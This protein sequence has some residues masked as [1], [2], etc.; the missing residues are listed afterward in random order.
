MVLD[1]L[2]KYPKE[3]WALAKVKT[4]SLQNEPFIHIDSD[5][6]IWSEF[7]ERFQQSDLVAQ[8]FEKGTDYYNNKFS[9]V[10]KYLKYIPDH[11]D[12]DINDKA[13]CSCN[14]GV[15]GGT[16]FNFF[17]KYAAYIFDFADGNDL[18]GIPAHV[19][20]NFNILFEQVFF[21]ELSQKEGKQI[22]CLFDKTIDD[23]GYKYDE[24]ADF[25]TVPYVNTYL[26]LIGPNKRNERACD[27]MSRLLLK[28]HPECFFKIISLFQE[29][30][31]HFNFN[32]S[33]AEEIEKEKI[34]S[35]KLN[36]SVIF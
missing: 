30:H 19:L 29:S 31:R 25:T 20:T 21:Y 13:V 11:F 2:Q 18:N 26:H 17:K 34:K 24:I 3:L 32:F 15:I 8:N 9:E 22:T 5:A 4:Y 12:F 10:K 14:A 23:C 7:G 35:L 27:L 16:D 28:E 33:I 6:F 36:G 1:D